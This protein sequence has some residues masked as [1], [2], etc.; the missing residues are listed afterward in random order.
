MKLI[1]AFDEAGNS[2][3]NLLDADQPVFVLASVSLDDARTR[4]ILPLRDTEFKFATLKRSVGG[5]QA[6]VDILN[7][8][9]LSPSSYLVSGFHKRFMALTKI[10][11][12]LVEPLAHRDGVDLYERGANLALSNMSYHCLP[13]FLGRN[14]FDLLIERFVSLVRS[15]NQRTIQN[16]YQLLDTAYRKHGRESFASDI[17]VLLSTR[18]IAVAH[19]DTWSSSDLD[20]A[21][22]A[23][24]EHGSVW[25]GR[26][27]ASFTIVH[28]VSKPIAD[29]QIVLEA[30]MSE[31][32][33]RQLI[34]YDRRKMHF[35][36]AAKEI[37]LRDS[38]S[39]LQIQ[40]ADIIASSVAYCLKCSIRQQRDDLFET[41]MQTKVLA[42]DF[43]PVWP[44]VKVSPEDLGTV[45]VGGIDANDYI[46]DYV[47]KR[48]GGIPE[49]GQRRKT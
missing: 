37:E 19:L 8:P 47:A 4:S 14:V 21:I 27:D 24:V 38:T 6:I 18:P 20:P 26:L 31:T 10:V 33:Q 40:L 28:D 12:L 29:E 32:D 48:L 22:P 11:D 15:P 2:G 3:G 7:A 43:R 13:V 44:E 35:P 41:L 42:G 34:G 25:T 16:F 49:K 23:F 17:A 39:C 45:E 5:R 46:G 9:A 36:I 1:V 30:M